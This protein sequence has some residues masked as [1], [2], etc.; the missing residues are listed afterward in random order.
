M[1]TSN[2]L[3]LGLLAIVIIGIIIVNIVLK[4]QFDKRHNSNIQL[5]QTV[6]DDTTTVAGDSIAM[7][8]AIKN[9]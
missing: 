6:P 1:K 7:D 5:E 8:K 3:I 9:E 4:K 2:K